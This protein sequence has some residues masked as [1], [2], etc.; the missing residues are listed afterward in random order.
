MKS[1]NYKENDIK[2]FFIQKAYK[3][4]IDE[5]ITVYFAK[6]YIV[7]EYF[8]KIPEGGKEKQ[9]IKFTVV[10]LKKLDL[11]Q[12]KLYGLNFKDIFNYSDDIEKTTVTTKVK[13]ETNELYEI[14]NNVEDDELFDINIERDFYSSELE[15][16]VEDRELALWY[17]EDYR[18]NSIK[19]N[20]EYNQ[21][22]AISYAGNIDSGFIIKDYS[23]T[24]SLIK[25]EKNSMN[26][27]ITIQNN[28]N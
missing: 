11:C 19:N 21:T 14:I 23:G 8:E 4:D 18:N 27:E 12:L 25:P 22:E 10:D 17:Y 13:D 20:E 26:Y 5:N 6:G 3:V 2:R 16:E 7:N 28:S 24:E 1:L 15:K 9:E